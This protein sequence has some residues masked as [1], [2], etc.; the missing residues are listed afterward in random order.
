MNCVENIYYDKKAE[1]TTL[2]AKSDTLNYREVWQKNTM[3]CHAYSYKN[4]VF[5]ILISVLISAGIFYLDRYYPS[6]SRVGFLLYGVP[7]YL[8]VRVESLANYF[9]YCVIIYFLWLIGVS[10]TIVGTISTGRYLDVFLNGFFLIWCY[11]AGWLFLANLLRKERSM[12]EEIRKFFAATIEALNSAVEAKDCYTKGH[13]QRVGCYALALGRTLGLPKTTLREIFVAGVMHDVGKIGVPDRVLNKPGSLT[14]DE[15][16]LIKEHC[17]MGARI[18]ESMGTEF[19]NSVAMVRNHHERYDGTGYPEGLIGERIGLGARIIAVAD[20]YDAILS[21]RVYRNRE[22]SSDDAL[23]E[24]DQVA[25]TQLDPQLVA[26]FRQMVL[27]N[28]C[29]L[30]FGQCLD[31]ITQP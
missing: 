12:R 19:A 21:P 5:L 18:V 25:G 15:Y 27:M 28:P 10:Q 14:H 31:W 22:T 23:Q 24:L 6:L 3:E 26:V 17:L 11:L 13:S 29:D 8:L 7:L 20:T 4:E 9:K 2:D 16:D 1:V 30:D